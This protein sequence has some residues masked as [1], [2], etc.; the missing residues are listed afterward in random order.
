MQAHAYS[1]APFDNA[2]QR[3]IA[4]ASGVIMILRLIT[5]SQFATSLVVRER[6]NKKRGGKKE[7]KI[8]FDRNV[9]L[10]R[11]NY[12]VEQKGRKKRRKPHHRRVFHGAAT[13]D[14]RTGLEN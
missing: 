7:A 5:D 11:D 4:R 2:L 10:R 1:R 9:K 3:E 6:R 13:S 14:C 12:I 8:S